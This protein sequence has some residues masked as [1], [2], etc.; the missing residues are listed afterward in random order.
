MAIA[1]A[2]GT[3]LDFNCGLILVPVMRNLI[4]LLRL[5][6]LSKIIP[7]D[8]SINFHKIVFLVIMIGS[9]FHIIAH[10]FDFVWIYNQTGEKFVTQALG[11]RAGLT[12][13]IILLCMF[14]MALTGMER[15]RRR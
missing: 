6:S 11:S 2:G 5:T 8:Y 10:Y 7:L 9:A 13:H 3:V 15:V 14:L 12:G 4:S 1:R